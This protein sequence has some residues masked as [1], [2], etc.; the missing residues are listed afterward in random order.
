MEFQVNSGCDH[1]DTDR[2][3][4]SMAAV[5]WKEERGHRFREIWVVHCFIQD[6]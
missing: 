3:N 1:L 4:N 2:R 5:V 6:Q